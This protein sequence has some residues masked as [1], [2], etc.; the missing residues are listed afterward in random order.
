MNVKDVVNVDAR[1]NVDNGVNI[2]DGVKMD[3]EVNLD[4]VNVDD[5]VNLFSSLDSGPLEPFIS[6]IF[7][8]VNDAR[9]FKA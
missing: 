5:G 8:D 7:D 2:D 4:V 3:D 1:V 9:H 6:M